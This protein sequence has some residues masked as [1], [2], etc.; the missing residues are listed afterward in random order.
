[1]VNRTRRKKK[2]RSRHPSKGLPTRQ[3][4]LN[5]CYIDFEGFADNEY[6][7][8]PPPV[9]IGL[10]RGG[11]FE[12]VVFTARYRWAAEDSGVD[13]DVSFYR[14]RDE[15]LRRLA[16]SAQVSKP[17]FGYSEREFK[18]IQ[19][20]VGDRITRRYRNVR[21]IAIR[22]LNRPGREYPT[23]RTRA[24]ADVAES[25]GI[26]IAFKLPTGE[27]TSRLKEVRD[28]SSSARKWSEAPPEIRENWSEVLEHN[29]SDVFAIRDIMYH[30]RQITDGQPGQR[31]ASI[32]RTSGYR[33]RRG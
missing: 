4:I 32:E 20:C 5:G 18:V 30:M 14:D 13:H 7:T 21:S 3:K 1:M 28:H 26:A 25:M 11:K 8:A 17:L 16:S 29:R 24:L 6:Q 12:Q 19:K 15:F 10:Y 22:W 2:T 31:Q 23:P 33:G 9:L 27:V